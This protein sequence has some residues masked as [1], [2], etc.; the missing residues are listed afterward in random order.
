M[1]SKKGGVNI[2]ETFIT[3]SCFLRSFFSTSISSAE[4]APEEKRRGG[5]KDSGLDFHMLTSNGGAKAQRKS[6]KHIK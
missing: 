4:M 5:E 1:T 2:E 6:L 3:N